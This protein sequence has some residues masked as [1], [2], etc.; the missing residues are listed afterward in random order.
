MEKDE[1]K[2]TKDKKCP[3]CESE[4]VFYRRAQ[5]LGRASSTSEYPKATQ[6]VWKCRDCEDVFFYDGDQGP[7]TGA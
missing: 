5:S 7:V 3:Y 1:I 4:N 6:E 2:T